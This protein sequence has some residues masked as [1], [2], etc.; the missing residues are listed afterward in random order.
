MSFLSREQLRIGLFPDQLILAGRQRGLRRTTTWEG[1]VPVAAS[2]DPRHWQPAVDTLAAALGEFNPGKR[3]VTVILSNH[4]VRYSL[5][6]WNAALKTADEWLALARHRLS[7]AHGDAISEW[8]IQVS[9]TAPKGPRVACAIDKPLLDTV[10]TTIV[11]SGARLASMQPLLV[12]AFNRLRPKAGESCWLVIAE[13]ACLTLVLIELGNWR[14]IMSRQVGE[15][16]RAELPGMLERESAILGL[17][18][19]YDE[20][21]VCTRDLFDTQPAP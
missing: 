6:P 11:G 4:F 8:E 7:S 14:A 5:L 20:V 15:E 13:A 1:T 19:P 21:V 3:E 12:A 16:W 9:E 18:Q 17:E 2:D 10:E